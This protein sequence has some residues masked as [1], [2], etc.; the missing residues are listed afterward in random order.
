VFKLLWIDKGNNNAAA[1][2]LLL[3]KVNKIYSYH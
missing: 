2:F 3:I 1:L